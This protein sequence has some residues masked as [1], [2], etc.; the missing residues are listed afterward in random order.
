MLAYFLLSLRSLRSLLHWC[1]HLVA[2][3]R[4]GLPLGADN[5]TQV[6]LAIQA[7]PDPGPHPNPS[8]NTIHPQA[9][10][11]TQ[12]LTFICSPYLMSD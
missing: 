7:L 1:L 8:P 11:A 2:V 9:S 3:A 6:S 5:H 10:L 4:C 12:A